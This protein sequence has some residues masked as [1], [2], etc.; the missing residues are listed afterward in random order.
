MNKEKIPRPLNSF[1]IYRKHK[2]IE[3]K[4]ENPELNNQ[5]IS[6]IVGK[7]WNNELDSVK[8]HYHSLAND[9]KKKHSLMFPNYKFCPKRNIP[10]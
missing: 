9:L 10:R 5:M 7:L 8:K 4:K 3:V 1:L 6:K 2:S